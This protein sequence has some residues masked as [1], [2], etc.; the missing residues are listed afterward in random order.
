MS[1][2]IIIIIIIIHFGVVFWYGRLSKCHPRFD[3]GI[4]GG[5]LREGLLSMASLR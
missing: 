2:F 4:G 1:F 5:L 3:W